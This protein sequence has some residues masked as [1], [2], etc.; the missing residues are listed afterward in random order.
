[1]ATTAGQGWAQTRP[2]PKDTLTIGAALSLTGS[3]SREGVLTREGYDRC[4]DAVNRKGGV[5]AG[6]RTYRLALRYQDDQSTPDVASRLVEQMN[7]AGIK[8]LLGPYGSASTEA[9]AAVVERN[10]QVMVEGA[11]ADDKIFAK[12]Y[13]RIFAVLSP[14]TRY[15]ASIVEA[16][17]ELS[18]PKPKRVAIISADDGFSK[19]AAEGG[20]AEANR[21]GLDVVGV[22]Y[23]PNGTTD[24]SGALTKLRPLRPD[25]ILGSVHLQEGIAIV[26]QS[27]EL[28]LSPA[29]GFGETVAPA[30]PDF[31]RT[32]GK[33]AEGVLGSSQWTPDAS[34]RDDWFGT[35]ADYNTAFKARYGRD[36]VYHNAEASAACLAMVMAIERAGSLEPDKVRSA[37]AALDADT[38]FGPIRFDATGKNTA[39]PMY[40][41]QIQDS[42]ITTVWPRGHLT[43]PVRPVAAPSGAGGTGTSAG[44][45]FGQSTVYGLLQGGL[46]GLVG[47]GF[48]LV[49]GVTNIVNLS[50]GALVV[51]GAYIA[52]ELSATFGLDPLLGM[53]V[54]ALVLFLLGYA[55]QRGLINLV[56]NAPIFMTLLLTFGLELVA[57]NGLVATLTGDY[58][59]IPTGYAT[60]AFA[61]GGVRVPYGRLVGFGLAVVLTAALSMF[62]GRTRTGRAIRATGM[63][64]GAARLMGIPVAHIYAVTFGLAAALAGAAGAVIGTVSTFSPAAAGGFTLRSFVVAV[65]GGLG[66]MWGALA[67]GILLGVVEAWG[68][69][70]LSGTLINAIAFAVLVVVLIVR[71]AGLLGRPFYEARI[72]AA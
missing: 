11:G 21:R 53:V 34:G 57:V 47:V 4:A 8:L 7:S 61:V 41:I 3:L 6:D 32:L 51:G 19:T 52:W 50:H 60:R 46:Y 69:Q 35:A 5:H 55:V 22:E 59:S 38:F 49:W 44:E 9:A 15:L 30:T 17:V 45:R 26:K 2:A 33:S 25:L 37:L 67:G 31:V 63:D 70:Y 24:V 29:G 39:K 66:N 40:V 28:G 43:Q 18:Q 13:H 71:P 14:A 16:A 36:A 56:M 54:A 62:L 48:S 72:E 58:R 27:D 65:L 20:R 1:L 23:V 42:R 68:G 12:G 64:R 10:G